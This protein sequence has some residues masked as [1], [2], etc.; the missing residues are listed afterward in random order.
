MVE[1]KTFSKLTELNLRGTKVGKAGFL[2][3]VFSC[4]LSTCETEVSEKGLGE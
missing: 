2:V 1:I 3:S 4:N